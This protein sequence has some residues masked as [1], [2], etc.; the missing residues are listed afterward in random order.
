MRTS[1]LTLASFLSA[2]TSQHCGDDDLPT[3]RPETNDRVPRQECAATWTSAWRQEEGANECRVVSSIGV[4]ARPS[5]DAPANPTTADPPPD[6]TPDPS[7]D[8]TPDPTPDPTTE[9]PPP[10]DP[11]PSPPPSAPPPPLPP[12]P[13]PPPGADLVFSVDAAGPATPISRFIYGTNTVERLQGAG[14]ALTLARS[15]GNRFSTYNWETNA[16]NA[17]LHWIQANDGSLNLDGRPAAPARQAIEAALAVGGAAIVTVPTMGWVSADMNGVVHWGEPPASRFHHS[18]ANKPGA[19]AASP[20]LSDGVVYQDEFVSYLGA[21]YP[22]AFSAS[23]PMVFFCLDN[24]PS[25]WNYNFPFLYFEPPHIGTILESDVTY[26]AMIKRVQPNSLVVGPVLYGWDA[27]IDFQGAV[28]RFDPA[29]VGRTFLE[30]YLSAMRQAELQHGRRLLDALDLHWYPEATGDG[31]RIISSEA[32]PGLVE[33]RVQAPRS[34]WD[35]TYVETSWITRDRNGGAPIRLLPWLREIIASAYPG[36][37]LVISEYNYGGGDHISG[38]IAE[39]DVLGIF[40][41]EGVFAAALWELE[42][43][44]SPFIHAGLAMYRNYDG[45]GGSFG[46]LSLRARTSDATTSSVY[47]SAHSQSGGR[48]TLVVINKSAAPRVAHIT[49]GATSEYETGSV[50][51]LTESSPQPRHAGTLI[52][53]SDGSFTYTMPPASVSTLVLLR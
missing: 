41:R 43:G 3:A 9:P 4:D 15:S 8:P 17:G 23:A 48:L 2:L 12:P 50:F 16:S 24:E 28:D 46:D 33:A 27:F 14:G 22:Q 42:G 53:A 13:P 31:I 32:T 29:Y 51:V 5:R 45:A 11:P 6:P 37:R 20:N 36:T 40:G 44:G 1:M 30:I 39:A 34:L 49:L 18:V 35:P 19:L 26:A 25:L 10:S 38:A 7:S 21:Q 52:A 47:A